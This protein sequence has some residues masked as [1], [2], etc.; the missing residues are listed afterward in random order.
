MIAGSE[1][2]S[3]LNGRSAPTRWHLVQILRCA[4][5]RAVIVDNHYEK[6]TT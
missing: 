4:F 1:V 2:E 3:Y 6:R 5:A